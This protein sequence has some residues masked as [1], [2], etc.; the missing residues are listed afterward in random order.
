[1][2]K[3]IRLLGLVFLAM[4][5]MADSPSGNKTTIAIYQLKATG[6]AD[7]SVASALTSLLGSALTPSP[8][9]KVIEDSMLKEVMARQ[10]QNE[11]DACDDT[12]CQVAIGKLAKAQKMINGDLVKLGTRYILSLKLTD[13]E[14]GTLDFSTKDECACTDDQ[15]DKLVETAGAKIRNH[16]G[17][18]VP[19]PQLPGAPPP[20]QKPAPAAYAPAAYAPPAYAPAPVAPVAPVFDKKAA[21][22]LEIEKEQQDRLAE[23]QARE[24]KAQ[25]EKLARMAVAAPPPVPAPV[26]PARN[27]QE[28]N[29]PGTRGGPMVFVSDF[30]FYIDRYEVSNQNYQE[31]VSAGG[32]K[33]NKKYNGFTDPQQPAVGVSQDDARAYCQWAGKRLPRDSEWTSAAVG[34]DNRQ[35]PWGNQAP[36]C[37]LANFEDCRLGKTLPVGSKPAGASPY[38]AVDMAG[39]AYEWVEEDR[40]LRG[41]SF[42]NNSNLIRGRQRMEDDSLAGKSNDYG[43]RCAHN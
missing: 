14:S 40:V 21:R 5:L 6:A 11:S 36:R 31:C 27:F 18:S 3:A 9:L 26:E 12:S 38:G 24:Q 32:C 8:Y 23:K 13:V 25:Q 39:N 34:T 10:V 29:L 4:I 20:Q 22:K 15:V 35:Y 17:E 43:F 16:F 2:K 28:F 7:K 37:S 33:S 41:G 19:V 42:I 1:M 30:N